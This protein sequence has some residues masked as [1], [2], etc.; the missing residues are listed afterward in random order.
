MKNTF[1]CA[2]IE[3]SAFTITGYG[4]TKEEAEAVMRQGFTKHCNAFGCRFRYSNAE[5][6]EQYLEENDWSV[7]ELELGKAYRDNEVI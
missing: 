2:R 6:P 1:F 4:S 7:T 5:T 3:M